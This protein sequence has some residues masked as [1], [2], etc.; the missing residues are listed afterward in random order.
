MHSDVFLVPVAMTV[1]KLLGIPHD[2]LVLLGGPERVIPNFSGYDLHSLIEHG[3]SQEAKF[4][5]I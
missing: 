1:A 3:L 4:V 2:H 5:E